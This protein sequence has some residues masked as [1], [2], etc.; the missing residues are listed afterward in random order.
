MQRDD[1]VHFFVKI[2]VHNQ[3]VMFFCEK[4]FLGIEISGEP[5]NFAPNYKKTNF[6]QILQ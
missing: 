5:P 1:M 2:F 3:Q 6:D 4:Y